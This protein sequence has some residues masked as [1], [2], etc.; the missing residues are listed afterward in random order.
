M[1]NGIYFT[2][3]MNIELLER[4]RTSLSG[5][6]PAKN[7]GANADFK[8]VRALIPFGTDNNTPIVI[9][10]DA[11]DFGHAEEILY[12]ERR[13]TGS[14]KL[15]GSFY[16]FAFDPKTTKPIYFNSRSFRRS[17]FGLPT[18]YTREKMISNG[19]L[20][21]K[22]ELLIGRVN[23]GSLGQFFETWGVAPTKTWKESV[24]IIDV[25]GELELN[26]RH[27]SPVFNNP[28]WDAWIFAVVFSDL[29]LYR[30]IRNEKLKRMAMTAIRNWN[31]RLRVD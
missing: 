14:I 22:D 4:I 19:Y 23:E 9:G 7:Q 18:D 20:P 3:S 17:W 29:T 12:H 16:G 2:K 15:F 11:S 27:Y 30:Q 1:H 24:Q 10:V 25:P 31:P 6:S 5:L 28:V 21:K 26:Y 8:N 13:G